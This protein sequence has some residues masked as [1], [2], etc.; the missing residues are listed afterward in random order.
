VW[1]S[2]L[3]VL[4]ELG[5]HQAGPGAGCRINVP[6]CVGESQAPVN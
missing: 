4:G 5:C 2:M 3:L 6:F 1:S